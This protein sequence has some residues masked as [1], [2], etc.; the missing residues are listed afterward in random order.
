MC[1]EVGGG[2]RGVVL[3]ALT[4]WRS[5]LKQRAA[6]A[7]RIAGTQGLSAAYCS[8]ASDPPY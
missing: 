8:V 4:R 2:V 7:P 3:N 5:R 6:V 1:V